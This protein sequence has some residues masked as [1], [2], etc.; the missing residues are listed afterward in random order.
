[1]KKNIYLVII[2]ILTVGCIV[3]G[4]VYHTRNIKSNLFD[5]RNWINIGKG[6]SIEWEGEDGKDGLDGNEERSFKST[7]VNGEISEFLP[8]FNTID[9]NAN[10]MSVKI[11]KGSGFKLESTF[12]RSYLEPK[13]E[14]KDGVLKIV[15]KSGKNTVGNNNANTIIYVPGYK[16]L[17]E[18]DVKVNVGEIQIEDI[19]GKSCEI[20]TN[21]GEILLEKVDFENFDLKANVGEIVIDMVGNLDDYS[22]DLK[23]DIG[24]VVVNGRDYKRNYNSR[25]S[26][27]KSI[28]AKSNVGEIEVR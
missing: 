22:L 4:T 10:V 24:E 18:I 13:F 21:V 25:G 16:F 11:V 6:I 5:F 14:V 1:M 19:A 12:N 8:E 15:Q 2:S 26:T 20:E 28:E 9:L 7:K 17:E 3:F 27:K 23:S